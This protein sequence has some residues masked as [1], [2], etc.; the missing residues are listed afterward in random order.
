MAHWPIHAAHESVAE[1]SI[2]EETWRQPRTAYLKL[3]EIA[4]DSISEGT[5]R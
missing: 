4:E 3:P 5:W 2:S 1:N